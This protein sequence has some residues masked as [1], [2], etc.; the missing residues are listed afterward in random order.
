M[1][2]DQIQNR[3]DA[4]KRHV[5]EASHT[6]RFED[7]R[8]QLRLAQRAIEEALSGIDTQVRGSL[9]NISLDVIRKER[10]RALEAIFTAPSRRKRS[11]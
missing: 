3:L 9:T 4:A 2:F 1:R 5:D 6:M 8:M 10:T 7:M 11:K